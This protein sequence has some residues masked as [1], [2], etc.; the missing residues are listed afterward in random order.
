MLTTR[1]TDGLFGLYNERVWQYRCDSGYMKIGDFFLPRMK[2]SFHISIT[3]ANN[4]TVTFT[5]AECGPAAVWLVLADRENCVKSLPSWRTRI[6]HA[7][8]RLHSWGLGEWLPVLMRE[9]GESSA[10]GFK[11]KFPPGS[12]EWQALRI[13]YWEFAAKDYTNALK[14]LSRDLPADSLLEFHFAPEVYNSA[15]VLEKEQQYL[16]ELLECFARREFEK[17]VAL[18]AQYKREYYEPEEMLTFE[19][20]SHWIVVFA[21]EDDSGLADTFRCLL[22]EKEQQDTAK[23]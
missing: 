1:V 9:A 19:G 16:C 12:V 8:Q 7:R 14:L 17:L 22:T 6:D 13:L 5:L 4:P 10:L 11:I 3:R 20:L 18:P 15:E 2:D 23:E 21:A